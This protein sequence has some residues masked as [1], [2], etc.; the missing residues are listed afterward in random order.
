LFVPEN[1]ENPDESK[2]AHEKG[3]NNWEVIVA[4]NDGEKFNQVWY[5]C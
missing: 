4:H 5:L 2:I 1:K 3:I